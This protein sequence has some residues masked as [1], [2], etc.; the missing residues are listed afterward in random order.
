MYVTSLSVAENE[1]SKFDEVLAVEA[2]DAVHT[3]IIYTLLMQSYRTT[4]FLSSS[5][6]VVLKAVQK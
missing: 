2:E 5:S 6:I 4:L 3:T 1:G